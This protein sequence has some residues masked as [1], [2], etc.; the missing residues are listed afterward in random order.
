MING[1]KNQQCQVQSKKPLRLKLSFFRVKMNAIDPSSVTQ[2]CTCFAHT[3]NTNAYTHI[4]TCAVIYLFKN[5]F[6]KLPCNLLRPKT[7]ALGRALSSVSIGGG[8]LKEEPAS[9]TGRQKRVKVLTEE[10]R[11]AI[12]SLT[13]PDQM[14]AEE[15]KRQQSALDRRLK[16]T[17]TLPAGVLAKWENASTTK[18]KRGPQS[19]FL[20]FIATLR[21]Y[22]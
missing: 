15:R 7:A 4:N 18:D 2:I 9:S 13:S 1:I 11:Q 6:L 8:I 14:S 19:G 16:K 10:Q 20:M 22:I 3:K 12:Q 5:I 21:L 17:D